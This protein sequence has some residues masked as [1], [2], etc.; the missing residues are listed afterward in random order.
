ME[1]QFIVM[2]VDPDDPKRVEINAAGNAAHAAR[3]VETLLEAGYGQER[4]RVFEGIELE[5]Q[6]AHRPVVSLFTQD[7]PETA[8]QA[9]RG[10]GAEGEG[11]QEGQ[12]AEEE[13]VPFVQN[14][15][16]FSS[17]FKSS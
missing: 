8:I 12:G 17:L 16:R 6:V 15:V 10:D 3:V 5:M 14:G 4:I 9:Q 7:D 11:G 13:G 1:S 2:V